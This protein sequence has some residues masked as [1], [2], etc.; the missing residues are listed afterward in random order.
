[1]A[2]MDFLSTELL[3]NFSLASLLL[4]SLIWIRK[5]WN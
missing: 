5:R 2:A 1:M 4:V 3:T